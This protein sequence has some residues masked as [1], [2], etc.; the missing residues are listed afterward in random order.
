MGIAAVFCYAGLAF[1]ATFCVEMK[2]KELKCI[3]LL[4]VNQYLGVMYLAIVAAVICFEMFIGFAVT[5]LPVGAWEPQVLRS[6]AGPAR[7]ESLRGPWSTTS[8]ATAPPTAS[9]A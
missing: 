7:H 9:S 5:S 3:E 4:L 1:L 6:T 8:T 2:R